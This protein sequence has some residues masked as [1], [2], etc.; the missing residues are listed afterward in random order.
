MPSKSQSIL[1]GGAAMGVAAAIFSLIPVGPIGSCLGC[2]ITIGAGVLA[3]W[4]YTTT[5]N[6]T[7][8]GGSGAGMGAQAGVVAAIVSALISF[9]LIAIGIAP[10]PAE[11]INQAIATGQMDEETG[12]MVRGFMEGPAYYGIVL[13]VSLI[14][15]A[16]AGAIGG[17]IGA[18][19]FQ[20]GDA[21]GP[22]TASPTGP[23]A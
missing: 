12:D 19:M 16:I 18:A 9:V 14:I 7:I 20:K 10:D 13:V 1:L 17:A 23:A 6:L 8:T 11:A 21:S 5:Y 22:S 2:I 15:G 4:H 3:V